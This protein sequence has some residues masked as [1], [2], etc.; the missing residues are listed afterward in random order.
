[1]KNIFKDD[2]PNPKVIDKIILTRCQLLDAKIISPEYFKENVLADE[3][4]LDQV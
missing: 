1:M 3:I 4:D 2:M